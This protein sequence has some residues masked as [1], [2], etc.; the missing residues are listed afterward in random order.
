LGSL[1]DSVDICNYALRFPLCSSYGDLAAVQNG[2]GY[3]NQL[4]M[5]DRMTKEPRSIKKYF[6]RSFSPFR[7]MN[8][9]TSDVRMLKIS[10]RI[11]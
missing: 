7:A 2:N 6:R 10:N 11:K 4:A 9:R 1:R 3:I 8:V 5:I